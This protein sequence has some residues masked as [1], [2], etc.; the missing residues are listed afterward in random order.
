MIHSRWRNKKSPCKCFLFLFLPVCVCSPPFP[1]FFFL[2]FFSLGLASWSSLVGSWD[3]FSAPWVLEEDEEKGLKFLP[4]LLDPMRRKGSLAGAEEE[5]STCITSGREKVFLGGNNCE[6]VH[7]VSAEDYFYLFWLFCCFFG[8]QI[9]RSGAVE[10][11]GVF[12]GGGWSPLEPVK[13]LRLEVMQT[14]MI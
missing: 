6:N 3:S 9:Q 14:G 12:R 4:I 8:I 5:S 10:P 2:S 13:L 11:Y 7:K 1:F